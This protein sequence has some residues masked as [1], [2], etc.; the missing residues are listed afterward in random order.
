MI[1][2]YVSY[3]GYIEALFLVSGILILVFDARAYRDGRMRKEHKAAVVSGWT[4]ITLSLVFF[5]VNWVFK[6]WFW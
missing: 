3:G 2:N 5:A 1:G 6:T 4:N